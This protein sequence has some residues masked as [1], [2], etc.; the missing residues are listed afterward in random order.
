MSLLNSTVFEVKLKIYFSAY[1]AKTE[2]HRIN[3]PVQSIGITYN[4]DLNHLADLM[5]QFV[6]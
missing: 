6:L 4:K 2:A 3:K 1:I 5:I